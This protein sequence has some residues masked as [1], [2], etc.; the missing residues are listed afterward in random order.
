VTNRLTEQVTALLIRCIEDGF[1]VEIE[2][3]G[4][5]HKPT[6]KEVE[7]VAE[8][9][10]MVFI[11]YADEDY[12]DVERLYGSLAAHGFDPWLDKKKLLP[13]QNWPRAIER[14]IEIS[15]FFIA[16]FSQRGVGRRGYFH[17]ELRYALDCASRLP[18]GEVFLVPVRLDDCPIPT[19][20]ASHI[21]Y[22][23]LFPGWE[24]GFARLI[25]AL[26]NGRKKGRPRAA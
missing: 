8:T 5:F 19:Q 4:T 9:R 12:R 17:S 24:R 26:K 1:P 15:D 13:G 7:F 2:G 14:T 3:L 21:Q 11:A 22:V 25:S 20:I 18:L 23:D 16:C 6:G 10:P